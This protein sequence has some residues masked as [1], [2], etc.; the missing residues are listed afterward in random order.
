ME[1]FPDNWDKALPYVLWSYLQ[2]PVEGFTFSSFEQLLNTQPPGTLALL[3]DSWMSKLLV[4][5]QMKH[6]FNYIHDM[7]NKM[8]ASFD[9]TKRE[10]QIANRLYD[11]NEVDRMLHVR[12]LVLMYLPV[13]GKSI[14]TKLHGPD[15]ALKHKVNVNYLIETPDRR[16]KSTWCHVNYT[17]SILY[18]C[19]S[20]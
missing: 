19:H 16:S 5:P 4:K 8:Q 2:C 14:A 7:K 20:V 6:V 11:R 15:K 1:N 18:S 17:S 12:Q 9:I 10:T 13:N 3:E